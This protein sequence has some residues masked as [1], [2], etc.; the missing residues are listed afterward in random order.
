MINLFVGTISAG[1]LIEQFPTL[2]GVEVLRFTIRIYC[3][4]TR[5]S[6]MII[7]GA[8]GLS[9]LGAKFYT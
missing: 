8:K 2:R 4:V 1:G 6:S 3:D 9:I 5:R 7:N